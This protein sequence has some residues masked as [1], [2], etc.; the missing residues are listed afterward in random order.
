M[1]QARVTI[2]RP[3]RSDGVKNITISIEDKA[4]GFNIIKI[5]MTAESFAECITGL[6]YV[7]AVIERVPTYKMLDNFG[8]KKEIMNCSVDKPDGYGDKRDKVLSENIKRE[9]EK[10]IG[11]GWM[12][13]DD[14]T[15]SQQNT[16]KHHFSL[17]RYVEEADK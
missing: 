3:Q 16:P 11:D 2:S 9:V 8:K 6:G 5:A 13:S 14:G 4:S 12:L 17:C 7:P 1:N 10:Y 15:R